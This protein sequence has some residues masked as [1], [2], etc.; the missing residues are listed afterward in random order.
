MRSLEFNATLPL[1]T[2]GLRLSGHAV[3]QRRGSPQQLPPRL[4]SSDT[5]RKETLLRLQD[6]EIG[7]TAKLARA[8]GVD[9]HALGARN[10]LACPHL[11][12]V[13]RCLVGCVVLTNVE[14]DG[15]TCL[16]IAQRRLLDA[17][18]R[19]LFPALIAIE[20]GQLEL[21][22]W[23]C[24]Q[25]NSLGLFDIEQSDEVVRLLALPLHLLAGRLDSQ[26]G[27]A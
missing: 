15:T 27:G 16:D 25:I 21:K 8:L 20:D 11:L 26:L 24:R 4:G 10:D 19:T 13:E 22:T 12:R 1:S 5:R 14:D 7:N 18:D 3:S 6:R 17:R 2:T 9:Q 23:P